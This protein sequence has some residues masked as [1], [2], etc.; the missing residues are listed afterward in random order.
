MTAPAEAPKFAP[1]PWKWLARP[2]FTAWLL[3]CVVSLLDSGG[4]TLGRVIPS[5]LTWTW[6][7][8]VEA[9]ALAAVWKFER[10][11]VS[12][13]TAMDGFFAGNAPW[14]LWLIA[15]AG[16]RSLFSETIWLGLAA[17]A[18]A[19][20]ALLDYRFFRSIESGSPLRD[21]VVERVLAWV[22][23][24]LLF[25]GASLVPGLIERMQ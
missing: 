9:L 20:T 21:L 11:P 8:L 16:C 13:T 17:V 1:P 6:V 12:F 10:R 4:L 5:S 14:W 25:G 15:F 7:P 18:G 19:G 22:P 2:L 23:S 3:G 24:I